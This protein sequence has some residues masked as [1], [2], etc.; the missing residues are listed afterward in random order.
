[1]IVEEVVGDLNE[2]ERHW[3]SCKSPAYNMTEGGDGGAIHNQLGNRWKVKDSS[4]VGK[5]LRNGEQSQHIDY[6]L[7]RSGNN[8]Q[9]V[10]IIHTPWGT[11]ETWKDATDEAKRLRLTFGRTD[12]IT[13]KDTLRKYC[14]ESVYL[15]PEGRRTFPEW[16][17]KYTKDIGFYLESK[18][19]SSN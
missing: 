10:N 13:D 12:V 16:R 17:G 15:N 1:M 2:R 9:S 4:R 7:M 18:N 14:T 8:Y 11:F 6:N 3:I 19:G 5:T